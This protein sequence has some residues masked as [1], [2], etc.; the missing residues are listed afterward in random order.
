[1]HLQGEMITHHFK[2]PHYISVDSKEQLFV[3]DIDGIYIFDR[4]GKY[5]DRFWEKEAFFYPKVKAVDVDM[6]GNVYFA[7]DDGGFYL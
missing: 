1:M 5:I 3:L 2:E 4:E 6:E 7:Q